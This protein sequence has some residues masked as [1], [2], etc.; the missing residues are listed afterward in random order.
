MRI[1][2]RLA[3]AALTAFAVAAVPGALFSYRVTREHV[4]A[5]V[6]QEV[7]AHVTWLATLFQSRVV[8]AENTLPALQRLLASALAQP[9]RAGEL[10]EFDRLFAAGDDSV[11]RS[12]HDAFD[13]KRE[14]GAY[15]PG[16][17]PLDD[18]RKR[19]YV[20]VKGVLDTFGA[21]TN[22]DFQNVWLLDHHRALV[23]F[24]RLKPDFVFRMSREQDYTQTAWMTLTGPAANP[25]RTLRWTPV[26][27]DPVPRTWMVSAV[28][29]LDVGDAWLGSVG[30]DLPLAQL[31][32]TLVHSNR[33]FSGVEH[34]LLDE[35]GSFILAGPWQSQ[36]M[37]R[38]R[39]L[40]D[41]SREPE[42]DRLLRWQATL[43]AD[44]G[45]SRVVTMRGVRYLAVPATLKTLNWKYVRL[46]P[47]SE[48][49][50]PVHQLF[51]L[52][53]KSALLIMLLSG[54]VV[55]LVTHGTLVQ[56]IL[57]LATAA[58]TYGS[59]DTRIRLGK[60]GDDELAEL[61]LSFDAMADGLER[62]QTELR[63]RE[64]RYR[65]VVNSVREVIFQLGGEGRWL[66]LSE[67]WTALS[68]YAIEDTLGR[69]VY[70][71]V[72]VEDVDGIR[73]Q[74]R[75]LTNHEIEA[76]RCEFR[77]RTR[78]GDRLWVEF[79]AQTARSSDGEAVFTGTMDDVSERYYQRE[80]SAL[81][82]RAE[83]FVNEGYRTEQLLQYF[84]EKL[85]WLFGFPLVVAALNREQK[86]GIV[87]RSDCEVDFLRTLS[88]SRRQNAEVELYAR[89][90]AEDKPLTLTGEDDESG[91]WARS[92][93]R[94][95]IGSAM[96]VPIRIHEQLG[97]LLGFH[98][99]GN[100]GLAAERVQR[101]EELCRRIGG[102][103]RRAEDLQW[104]RLQ[105]TALESV[106]NGIMIVD[107]DH[108]VI[109]I[110]PA[111]ERLSGYR[112]ED[113]IGRSTRLFSAGF[114]SSA[115]P[116]ELAEARRRGGTWSGEI[117]NR[118]KDG[119]LYTVHETVTALT[120]ASGKITHFVA[121]Q[122]D[123]TA[124]KDAEARL[125][126]MAT[127][128]ALTG[129]S[130]RLLFRERLKEAFSRANRSG[131]QVAVLLL[132]LDRFKAINDTLGHM[133]ADELLQAVAG[134]LHGCLREHDT[135]AR[136]GGDEFTVLLPELD[137]SEHAAVVAGKILSSLSE[138]FDIAGQP[139]TTTTSIGIS[140]YPHDG[141]DIDDILQRA[142]AA[143][144]QSKAMGRNTYQFYT[145]AIHERSM[146][147]L[148]IEKEL[149]RA[150]EHNE[151]VLHF[152]PIADTRS[153]T[154]VGAE[155]LVR[156]R[157]PVRGVLPPTAFIEVAEDSGLILAIGDWVLR[158]ACEQGA[159]WEA[160]GIRDMEMSV[161]LSTRQFR[162]SDLVERVAHA[163]AHAGFS[164]RSMHIELT[165]SLMMDDME[166]GIRTMKALKEL[167]VSISIDDF[168]VGYSSLA[169]LKR[170]PLDSLKID[171]SFIET[172]P[173]NSEATAIASTILAMART[174]GLSVVAEGVENEA[175]LEF[176][177]A[178]GCPRYQ[179]FLL[180]KPMSAEE[181]GAF[182]RR[183]RARQ[184]ELLSP[185]AAIRPAI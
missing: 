42:L 6:A 171:R 127:H 12:R 115:Q 159:A 18:D 46:I 86:L 49:L 137:T 147:R 43:D 106:A 38:G 10:E 172:V 161:N 112:R 20:R 8:T 67:A 75:A 54:V 16:S 21:H 30:F 28:Y 62:S 17:P 155:A 110:N 175:Q 41:L 96:V 141:I 144:Y 14:A 81:L 5:D 181:L 29:P 4:I 31:T 145:R 162:Q 39:A 167:G 65:T 122:A 158:A 146:Q 142:D 166:Q 170:F 165:E 95:G 164:S 148:S 36:L 180:G 152:Q 53:G 151:F 80:V 66:F 143:M 57:R 183:G 69:S 64:A 76:C 109:W 55:V 97:A 154:I 22:P 50:A 179:G 168:G 116:S 123:I 185:V 119:S 71:F 2:T 89:A 61:A 77:L 102:V 153:G 156:W 163:C 70:E 35:N 149:R 84:C 98:M 107:T 23:I 130:N 74:I 58:R 177:R 27:F 117:V 94:A 85:A 44:A 125:Q 100:A 105:R 63:Q 140:I 32:E 93:A 7:S 126:H 26:I 83:E 133:R 139:V 150:V 59:G 73:E 68:G 90:F 113:V 169:Y 103:L 136:L 25:V 124:L 13:G 129:L 182:I 87:G 72:A 134:R 37:T 184:A 176:L 15:I 174:L 82:R 131:N 111:M 108:E 160:Q 33:E 40:P 138:P 120:D 47:L 34:F 56:P 24:D 157:H 78:S 88:G 9:P 104:L 11:Y 114:S 121:V 52:I 99:R 128:D 135:V 132:D 91:E 178:L 79:L 92:A 101:M 118:R 45:R 19:F 173:Q 1:R 48:V 51:L 3:V 60:G